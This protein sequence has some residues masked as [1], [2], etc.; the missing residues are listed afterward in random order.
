MP[1]SQTVTVTLADGSIDAKTYNADGILSF[2]QIDFKDGHHQQ[3]CFLIKGAAYVSTDSTFDAQ[4]RITS[5]KQIAADGTILD[6]MTR[7]YAKDGA[8]TTLHVN[9]AGLT[10]SKQ[11]DS[12]DGTHIQITYLIKGMAYV[13]QQSNFDKNWKL[14]TQIFTD[15]KGAIVYTNTFS[16]DALGT[17]AMVTRNSANVITQLDQ[18]FA[19]GT[20]RVTQYGITGQSYVTL[21]QNYAA[22]KS[23]SSQSLID[24]AGKVME[25]DTYKYSATGALI[26]T[27]K[28]FADG[29]HAQ[30]TP[31]TGQD[32]VLQENDFDK[33]WKLT[34]QIH[35]NADGSI[36]D[37]IS[38]ATDAAGTIITTTMDAKGIATSIEKAFKDGHHEMT[39]Y[40]KDA[41]FAAAIYTY[42]PT[43][44]LLST[45]HLDASGKVTD[46]TSYKYSAA[47]N[48]IFSQTDYA[49]GSHYQ[50]AHEVTGKTY[51]D[52]Y[53]T[54]DSKWR[55]TGM[56]LFN[57]SKTPMLTLTGVYNA[58]GSN[59]LRYYDQYGHMTSH[60][61]DFAD[62]THYQMGLAPD[63]YIKSYEYTFDK[64]W[65]MIQETQ[66]LYNGANVVK[67]FGANG[68]TL[69]STGLGNDTMTGGGTNETFSF[70]LNSGRET[71]TDFIAQGAGHDVIALD[72]MLVADWAHL[73]NYM[74]QVG[75]DVQIAIDP[76]NIITIQRMTIANLQAN[77]FKFI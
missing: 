9:A 19:N 55:I 60:T 42:S 31:V 61:A 44:Q 34:K 25:T 58:D 18:T 6:T 21:V 59:D 77:D 68:L 29:T 70:K 49:D 5:Q 64:S 26:Q 33:Y 62:G 45:S 32:Y 39:V 74:H 12:A 20:H 53:M 28:D 11:V 67:G 27:Q 7:S 13:T 65:K 1:K 51:T 15:A 41:L 54:F 46:T 57:A 71:I 36:K 69:E 76:N 8:A 38:W 47:G 30:I 50:V 43:W 2:E 63:A 37:M 17:V 22:D 14:T 35:F 10:I 52:S 48:M 16:T 72:H 56:Q 66:V 4:W 75:G 73:Q 40:Y 24:S 3:K 23:L